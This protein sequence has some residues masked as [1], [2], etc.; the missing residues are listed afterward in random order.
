M[1][2]RKISPNDILLIM[3]A[4][5]ITFSVAVYIINTNKERVYEKKIKIKIGLSYSLQSLLIDVANEEGYFYKEGIEV[6]FIRY[7]SDKQAAEGMLSGKCD[8]A[9]VSDYAV[10]EESMKRKDFKII[11]SIS[12]APNDIKIVGRRDRMIYNPSKLKGKHIGVVKNSPQELW[13]DL[14]LASNSIDKMDL[15]ISYEDTPKLVRDLRFNKLDAI[16]CIEPAAMQVENILRSNSTQVAQKGLYKYNCLLIAKTPYVR[17]NEDIVIRFLM[18]VS[19]ASDYMA[20][21]NKRYVDAC[22]YRFGLSELNMANEL[23]NISFDTV[24][25]QDTIASLEVDRNWLAQQKKLDNKEKLPEYLDY[26]YEVCLKRV[27][28]QKVNILR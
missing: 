27:N 20:K 6:Q 23:K 3:M 28:P 8:I 22:S 18:A 25:N 4:F 9:A 1:N 19:K 10:A 13:L 5:L 12:S 16:V 7:S 14:L 15:N 21:D 2:K 11:S 26:I 24:L 17:K